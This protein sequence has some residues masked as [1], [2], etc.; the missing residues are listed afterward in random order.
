MNRP[1][2]VDRGFD[3]SMEFLGSRGDEQERQH[4]KQPTAPTAAVAVLP[5]A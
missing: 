5:Y 4:E 3:G 1:P 2:L